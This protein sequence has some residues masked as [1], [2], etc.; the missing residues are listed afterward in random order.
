M[1]TSGGGR[2]T[3]GQAYQSASHAHSGAVAGED[4]PSGFGVAPG[5]PS[6]LRRALHDLPKGAPGRQTRVPF[7]A[8]AGGYCPRPTVTT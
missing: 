2:C 8:P 7:C 5:Y 1:L 3:R 6:L 4:P